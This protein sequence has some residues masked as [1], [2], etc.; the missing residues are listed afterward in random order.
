[1]SQGAAFYVLFAILFVFVA[2]MS[3]RLCTVELQLT[4]SCFIAQY[5]SSVTE[6]G[7]ATETDLSTSTSQGDVAS[8]ILHE[9]EEVPLPETETETDCST[10]VSVPSSDA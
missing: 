5:R 3:F 4:Q 10:W 9:G 7:T 6:T 1:M 2:S 8:D